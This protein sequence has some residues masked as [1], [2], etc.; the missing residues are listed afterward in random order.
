[1]ADFEDVLKKAHDGYH[2]RD[3]YPPFARMPW[4][5]RVKWTEYLRKI[6][7]EMNKVGEETNE[8]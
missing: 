4:E 6:N 2:N 8:N 1:M 3:D 7:D 5:D